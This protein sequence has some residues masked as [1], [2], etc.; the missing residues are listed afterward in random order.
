MYHEFLQGGI[1]V[2]VDDKI[3]YDFLKNLIL[4]TDAQGKDTTYWMGIRNIMKDTNTID[5][6]ERYYK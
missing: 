3:A 1:L 4:K 2:D 5:P 6:N